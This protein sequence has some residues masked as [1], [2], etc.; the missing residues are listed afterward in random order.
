MLEKKPSVKLFLKTQKTNFWVYDVQ[1][2]L[3]GKYQLQISKKPTMSISS[4]PLHRIIDDFVEKNSSI[5]YLWEIC[6]LEKR[7][8]LAFWSSYLPN[9]KSISK[10]F[11]NN[12]QKINEHSQKLTSYD[13]EFNNNP[14]QF[15]NFFYKWFGSFK[16]FVFCLILLLFTCFGIYLI[17]E[18]FLG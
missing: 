5:H 17:F 6:I 12:I 11:A 14:Q 1:T 13:F 8:R 16:K 10:W 4:F 7:V 18:Y 2:S 3:P 9:Q 15:L